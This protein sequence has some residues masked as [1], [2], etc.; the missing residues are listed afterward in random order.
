MAHQGEAVVFPRYQRSDLGFASIRL[1][2][3]GQCRD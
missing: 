1:P 2:L 3:R